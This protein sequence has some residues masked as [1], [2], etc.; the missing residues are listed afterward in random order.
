VVGEVK[1]EEGIHRQQ[2]MDMF[3]YKQTDTH[4]QARTHCRL[5]VVVTRT[6]ARTHCHMRDKQ[7]AVY[8]YV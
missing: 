7:A 5:G 8:G 3:D 2:C 1:I 6:H 4:T